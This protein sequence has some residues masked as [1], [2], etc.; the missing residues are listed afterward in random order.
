MPPPCLGDLDGRLVAAADEGGR[1]KGDP[2]RDWERLGRRDRLIRARQALADHAGD[3]N[4]FI[5][6]GGERPSG[7][8]D[9]VEVAERLLAAGR[10]SE[11]LDWVRRPSRPGL[12]AMDMGDVA[13][14]SAGADLLDRRRVRVEIWILIALGQKDE[15]Q[16]L[17]WRTFEA[18][19]DDEI[20]HEYVA[21]LPDFEEFEALVRAFAYAEAHQHRYRSLGFFLAWPRLELAA[22]L[23]VDHRDSWAGQHYGA[24]VP[25]AKALEHDHPIAATV[26]YRALLDDIL[27]RARAPAYG[28]GARYLEKLDD[29]ASGGLTVAGLTS[30]ESYRGGLRRAHG[31][32]TA[33]WSTVD[34]AD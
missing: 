6:L 22:K 23:V 18:S 10:T 5:A 7:R 14:A 9:N 20:L 3:V 31:R 17:R 34:V 15:A 19:L 8:Q 1:S 12:R 29:L 2:L 32:K 25:A 26:L 28:H 21:N 16:D 11:A 33:F 24:L 13:D 30:H 4:R 27:T